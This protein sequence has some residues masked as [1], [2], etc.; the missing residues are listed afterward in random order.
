MAAVARNPQGADNDPYS[1]YNNNTTTA[2]PQYTGLGLQQQQ[3]QQSTE[4]PPQSQQPSKKALAITSR[5][6]RGSPPPPLMGSAIVL[7]ND[8]ALHC[9]GGRLDNRE[10]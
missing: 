10:L 7:V 4:T 3:Q 5:A 2:N 6:T 8:S 1:R 9:F